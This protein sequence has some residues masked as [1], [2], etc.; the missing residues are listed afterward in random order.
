MLNRVRI[1]VSGGSAYKVG[2]TTGLVPDGGKI[3]AAVQESGHL[4]TGH[5]ITWAES[6]T[7]RRVTS[8]GQ[9]ATGEPG[10][11]FLEL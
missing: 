4:A 5:W 7:G 6:I 2:G 3:V 10:N 9:P 1:H 8:S 11:R